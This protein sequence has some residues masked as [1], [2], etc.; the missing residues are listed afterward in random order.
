GGILRTVLGGVAEN[1]VDPHFDI[2]RDINVQ[3]GAD[4]E[5]F[6]FVLH[7]Q[8]PLLGEEIRAQGIGNVLRAPGHTQAMV[9]NDPVPDDLIEPIRIDIGNIGVDTA[10]S[11]SLHGVEHELYIRLGARFHGHGDELFRIGHLQYILGPLYAGI[12]IVLNLWLP[13]LA[14]G[15]GLDDDHPIGSPNPV[16]GGR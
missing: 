9:L 16:Y 3:F 4:V 14:P 11:V 12:P 6:V 7:V 5:A 13:V 10:P 15:L 8:K 1:R 2:V